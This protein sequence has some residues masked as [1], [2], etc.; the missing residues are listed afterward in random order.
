[1][2]EFNPRN[3]TDSNGKSHILVWQLVESTWQLAVASLDSRLQR[4]RRSAANGT[5]D[6]AFSILKTFRREIADARML[7]DELR[8]RFVQAVGEADS[9][10]VILPNGSDNALAIEKMDVNAFWSQERAKS[11]PVVF[12]RAQTMDI[13][14][15][16]D[17]LKGLED[18]I[19]SMT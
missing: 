15:L 9:W 17:T 8:G 12:G 11:A 5:S 7:I 6:E 16:P 13:K 3:V 1:M 18:W 19:H 4:I 10:I 2:P 14:N